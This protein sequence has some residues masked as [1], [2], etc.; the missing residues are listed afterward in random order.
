MDFTASEPCLAG[1]QAR[2]GRRVGA[3]RR[4]QLVE[5]VHVQRLHHRIIRAELQVSS[6]VIG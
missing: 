5:T 6:G 1:G 2:H 4:R 3:G